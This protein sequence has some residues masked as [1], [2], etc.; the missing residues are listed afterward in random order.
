MTVRKLQVKRCISCRQKSKIVMVV[1]PF[2]V[3][4][5]EVDRYNKEVY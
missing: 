3:L 1:Y 2:E 4:E 5:K